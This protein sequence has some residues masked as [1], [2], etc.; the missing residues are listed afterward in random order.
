LVSLVCKNGTQQMDWVF[1]KMFE[2]FKLI[3]YRNITLF[4]KIIW[5]CVQI[6]I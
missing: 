2:R 1:K 4:I 6:S 3:Q 5:I